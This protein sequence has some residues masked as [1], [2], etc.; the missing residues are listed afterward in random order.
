MKRFI[1]QGGRCPIIDRAGEDGP[2]LLEGAQLQVP[3]AS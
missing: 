2:E 3:V 1:E